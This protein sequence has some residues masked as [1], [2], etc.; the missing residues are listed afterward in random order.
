MEVPLP[1]CHSQKIP[2]GMQ[3]A[4]LLLYFPA[5]LPLHTLTPRLPLPSGK[6]LS[7]FWF[8]LFSL[9]EHTVTL[10]YLSSMNSKS[11]LSCRHMCRC[12]KHIIYQYPYY[13]SKTTSY[14]TLMVLRNFLTSMI[15]IMEVRRH[16]LVILGEYIWEIIYWFSPG[17]F[18]F[19]RGW[20]ESVPCL[21]SSGFSFLWSW[22]QHRLRF[23]GTGDL[24]SLKRLKTLHKCASLLYQDAPGANWW[25]DLQ[26][27]LTSYLSNHG[28]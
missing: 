25:N 18:F 1:P 7:Q 16:F 4:E 5:R 8:V 20:K 15:H 23:M 9:A 2:W 10:K 22:M 19:T 28:S 13:F 21:T 12:I 26:Y 24:R 11:S 3:A 27:C 17:R 14:W 6:Q